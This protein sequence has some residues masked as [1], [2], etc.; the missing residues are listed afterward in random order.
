LRF[1]ASCQEILLQMNRNVMQEVAIPGRV[2]PTTGTAA[3]NTPAISMERPG[4]R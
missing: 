4:H 1:A 3:Q 2:P